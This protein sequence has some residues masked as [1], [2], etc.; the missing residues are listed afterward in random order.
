MDNPIKQSYMMAL[1]PREERARARGF[2]TVFQRLS[3]SF[4]FS[5]AAYMMSAISTSMPFFIGGAI[6]FAHDISPFE[7]QTAGGIVEAGVG[8]GSGA[9]GYLRNFD[10]KAHGAAK[11]KQ[12]EHLAQTRKGTPPPSS[13]PAARGRKEEGEHMW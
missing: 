7:Y 13:Y 5:A 9:R 4:R 1:V 11:S 12:S 8:I 3:G 6:Q 2:T 10:D